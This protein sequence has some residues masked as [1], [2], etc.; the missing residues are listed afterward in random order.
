ME[1]RN[2]DC[3]VCLACYVSEILAHGQKRSRMFFEQDP[4]F[5]LPIEYIAKLADAGYVATPLLENVR[6]AFIT[7]H[8]VSRV[9]ELIPPYDAC[10]LTCV[11][12]WEPIATLFYKPTMFYVEARV[13]ALQFLFVVQRARREQGVHVLHKVPRDVAKIIARMVYESHAD[14]TWLRVR[15]GKSKK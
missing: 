9:L 4:R 13:A 5:A 1:S 2:G 8:T 6:I 7:S 3:T 15:P 14:K 11:S 10:L 12:Y